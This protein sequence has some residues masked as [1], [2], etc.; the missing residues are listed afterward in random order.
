MQ[1]G[2]SDFGLSREVLKALSEMGFEEPTP[3]QKMA[4]PPA[5]EGKDVIG[6]AQTGTGKTVAFG[7]PLVEHSSEKRTPQ[8]LVL[9]PTRELAVQIAEELNRV[10]KYRGILSLPIYGGQSIERQIRSLKK[11][12]QIVVGTPGRIIDHINRKT[13]SLKG[14]SSVVLDEA[15][16]MLNMGFINDI[17]QILGKTPLDRQTMLFSATLPPEILRVSRR[18][19]REPVRV[20]VNTERMVVSKIKQVFYEVRQNNKLKALSRI[21]DVE[22]PALALVFCHTKKEVDEV[23]SRLKQ[24]GYYAGAIH[25][26]FTQAH[27][28]RVIKQFKT[29]DIDILV[30]T[31]VAAR[32]LDISGVSHVINYS[33]PQNPDSYIHRIGRTGRAG[34]SGIAITFVT[35]REYK[36]LRLI[37]RTART[38]ILRAELPTKEDVQRVK[39]EELKD[40]IS[41]LIEKGEHVNYLEMVDELSERFS[42]R[43]IAASAL[44]ALYDYEDDEEDETSSTVRLFITLGKRDNLSV[45]DLVRLIVEKSG[46]NFESLGKIM[47]Y[48]AFSFVEVMEEAAP[49]VLRALNGALLK[50]RRIK[51]EPAKPKNRV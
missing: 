24:M 49:E 11:G 19:M 12:V 42:L 3:I 20:S 18:Y 9:A 46:V 43:D 26:D 44:S 22:D 31:D 4:I 17:E 41:E 13:L 25:G 47:M 5:L 45:G 28:D 50:G 10:G 7:I 36:N 37:E 34:R 29:G 2:F 21:I 23:S 30:A 40:E 33:I 51:A 14:I 8:A 48:D 15:D 16:E 1:I 6:R 39:L 27:R 38:R 35:P 32:G